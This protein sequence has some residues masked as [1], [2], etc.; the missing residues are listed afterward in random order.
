MSQD[1]NS[2]VLITNI[3][4]A[5]N[6]HGDEA[7]DRP[8]CFLVVGGDLNGT[9]IDLNEG[10][11]YIGRQA[12][13]TVVL[14]FHGISKQHFVVK[15]EQRPDKTWIY[16]ISDLGSTNGTF[17]NDQ[18]IEGLIELQ[19]NDI[20]K[21]GMFAFKFLPKGDPERLTYDKLNLEAN[22]DG[23]TKC[24]NKHY[25]NQLLDLE[26]KKSKA[27]GLPLSLIV[28][29]LDHFKGLNDNFG[30]DAGDFVLKELADITRKLGVREGDLFARYG[31]EEFV[32]LLP[33]TNLKN[34]FELAERIRK[35]IEN[36]DFIYDGKKLPVTA[37]LGVADF[38][39]GVQSGVELF[40]RA[41]QAAYFSKQ[42]GRNQVHYY[43]DQ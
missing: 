38:R 41:D 5:L 4:D 24:Y 9:I 22:T 2:T 19:K 8:A 18:K 14:E 12:T 28:F 7:L 26:V 21:V 37:S 34:S 32:I 20:V 11:T 6:S 23:L 1:E 42:R 16:Q 31:G 10:D 36:H 27:T 25:F 33:K 3:Y 40:K 15:V 43:R 29:D 35:L 13:N 39:P 30:H 17:V